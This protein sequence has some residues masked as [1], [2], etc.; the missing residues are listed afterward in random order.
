MKFELRPYQK[1]TVNQIR[2]A[3]HVRKHSSAILCIPTGGGK[4]VVFSFIAE[5]AISKGSTVMIACDR[6]ELIN[7]AFEKLKDYGLSPTIIAPG[8]RFIKNTCYVASVDTILRRNMDISIDI[9]IVDEAHK[10]KFDKLVEKYRGRCLIIGA[11]ATPIRKGSQNSLHKLY[12]DLVNPV[13][14]SDLISDG[15]LAPA[16]TYGAE[17]DLNS[18]KTNRLDYDKKELFD[19]Y[20]KQ[21]M[22]AGVVNNYKKFCNDGLTIIF[23]V[24]REHSQKTADEFV[25]NGI[26]A[27][28]V[29]G[30]MSD[31]SRT[32]MMNAFYNGEF[33]VLCNCMIATTGYDNP[34][35]KNV[36]VNRATLSLALWLQ[37]CGR[38]S[39]T[40]PGKTHFNIIDMGSNVKKHGFWE[41]DRQWDLVK[42]PK[43]KQEQPAPV[44][45]CPQCEAFVHA[46]KPVCPNCR[47]VFPKKDKSLAEAEFTQLV[48]KE[49]PE[50]LRKP[51]NEMS[52]QELHEYAKIKGYKPG[53]PYMQM[54]LRETEKYIRPKRKVS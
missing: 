45:S 22:Y 42:K 49:I 51:F 28:H 33:K 39:R 48:R 19:F 10:A 41:D 17:V 15:F 40:Y 5:S 30:S 24:N 36:I 44:K 37:M 35:I 54:K 53:W 3:F 11:T 46:S 12:Q 7:Q 31:F 47:F 50:H 2:N 27:R 14:V 34:R 8:K 29:D 4:T 25:L 43:S 18:I 21:T 32:R 1:N 52:Y 6:K 13:Q 9:L 20:N 23:N 16:V 38:G 26:D